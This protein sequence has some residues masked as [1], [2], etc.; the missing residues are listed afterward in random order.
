MCYKSVSADMMLT[1]LQY[2]ITEEQYIGV[3]ELC[4][5]LNHVYSTVTHDRCARAYA[6]LTV[7]PDPLRD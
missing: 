2:D 3:T 4:T 6:T 5:M 1:V 7:A